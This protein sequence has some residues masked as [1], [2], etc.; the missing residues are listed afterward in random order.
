MSD[1]T[2]AELS[3]FVEVSNAIEGFVR[4]VYGRRSGHPIYIQHFLA[5]SLV[6]G[7]A[8]VDPLEIHRVLMAGLTPPGEPAGALRRGRLAI[9]EEVMPVPSAI[10]FL[11]AELSAFQAA[12]PGRAL[13]DP[14]TFAWQVHHRFEAI[15]PF[16]DGNG[17]VGRLLFNAIR[18]R[19]GL[20][21]LTAPFLD[22]AA[23]QDLTARAVAPLRAANLRFGH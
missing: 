16:T 6:A 14:A 2:P 21:W 12:G 8:S 7:G 15:H 20:P 19:Y 10:P 3:D 9:R 18:R 22:A 4:S 5:A 1:P 13:V 23:Y 11:L 17:R